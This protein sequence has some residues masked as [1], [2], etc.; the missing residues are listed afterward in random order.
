MEKMI[1]DAIQDAKVSGDT[2]FDTVSARLSKVDESIRYPDKAG[3]CFIKVTRVYTKEG[4]KPIEGVQV[5]DYVLSSPEDGSGAP[6][7]KRVLKTIAHEPQPIFRISIGPEGWEF[8]DPLT[9]VVATGNH[10]FWVEGIGWT[11]ADMLKSGQRLRQGNGDFAVV[12]GMEPVYRT[13]K[14]GIGWVPTGTKLDGYGTVFNYAEYDVASDEDQEQFKYLP[15]EVLNSDDLFLR[16]PVFNIEVE[17][18]H[19]YYV[20]GKHGFWVRGALSTS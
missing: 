16:V 6:E 10:P 14:E 20:G 8:P 11:R 15:R 2:L 5:G 17:D 19:T 12:Y 9:A 3:G 1:Q 18:F 7:Y 4:R 13:G